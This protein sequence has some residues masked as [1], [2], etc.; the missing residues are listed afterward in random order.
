MENAL[1]DK[2]KKFL[3]IIGYRIPSEDKYSAM[4]LRIYGFMPAISGTTIMLPSDII[5]MSGT[6]FDIDKLFLM[7]RSVRRETHKP[8]LRQSIITQSKQEL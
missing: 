1:G 5:T 6:D 8:E 3:D 7:I 2:S 4:P